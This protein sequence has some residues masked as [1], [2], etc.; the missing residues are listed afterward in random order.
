MK[1]IFTLAL[2]LSSFCTPH[3][4]H[5]AEAKPN[6]IVI[7]TDDHGWADLG[8][9]GIQQDI[10][11][12]HLDALAAGGVRAVHGY[13]TAPQCVPSRAG[14]LSGQYQNRF[15]LESNAQ[16]TDPVV[17]GRFAA[18]HDFAGAAENGGLCDGHGGQVAPGAA[19][20]ASPTTASPKPSTSTAASPV[21]GT[22]TWRAKDVPPGTAD[23]R[24]LS[25]RLGGRLRQRL[26]SPPSR[27]AVLFLP[28]FRAP[29]TP[30][31]APAKYTARFPGEMPERR[32]QALAMIS[33]IDDGVGRILATLR[34]QGLEERTLIFFM[35]DNGAPLKFTRSTPRSTAT[36]AAGTARSMHR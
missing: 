15:G 4:S 35:G 36:R 18:L 8:A 22:W 13:V 9:Q 1:R 29:H 11:T 28:R 17:M 19:M 6:I 27:A 25:P 32:R 33:A 31:D 24:R 20:T 7:Y 3:T 16:F 34:E 23:R 12:P 2:L 26:H 30:L 21:S 10:R 14:L 5:A